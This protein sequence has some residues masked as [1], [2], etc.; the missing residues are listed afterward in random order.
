MHTVTPKTA[1]RSGLSRSGLYRA[2]RAGKLERVARGVYLPQF[3]VSV[4]WELAEVAARRPNA[5]V[6]LASALVQHELDDAIPASLDV[7]L[8][9]GARRPATRSAITWHLFDRKTFTIGRRSIKVVGTDLRIGLYSAERSI[10]DAFRM[11]GCVGYE[12]ATEALREW[13]RRG[14]KPSHL[15]DVAVQLPRAKGPVLQALE[16]LT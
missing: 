14:G 16:V 7:A 6:C 11:R 4:D 5:T 15:V 2:A 1:S 12:L 9:R 3:A 10:A 8:P 13:L